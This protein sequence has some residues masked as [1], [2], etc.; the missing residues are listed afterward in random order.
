[1]PRPWNVISHDEVNPG[2]VQII[3]SHKTLVWEQVP[4]SDPALDRYLEQVAA[5]HV[6]GG[7][8]ISR[9]RAVEYSDTTAWYLARRQLDEYDLLHTLFTSEPVRNGLAE[10]RIPHPLPKAMGFWEEWA[11]PLC[12]D[13]ILAGVIVAGGAYRKFPGPAREAKALGAAAAEALTQSRY[14]DFRLDMSSSEW[15][16]WFNGIGNDCTCVLTDFANAEVTVLC[17]TDVD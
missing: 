6:N 13:G 11:G 2:L 10:L 8:L 3:A 17:I 9:W 4:V 5:T 7:H 16:P 1:M 14:E 12:L 15:T